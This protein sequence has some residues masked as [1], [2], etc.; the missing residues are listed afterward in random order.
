MKRDGIVKTPNQIKQTESSLPNGS[1]FIDYSE[2]AQGGDDGS[3]PYSEQGFI[4]Q[5]TQTMS[6]LS[7]G[8]NLFDQNVDIDL[9]VSQ[10]LSESE[11]H[12]MADII[13]EFK[14]H[15]NISGAVHIETE[16]TDEPMNVYYNLQISNNN[17]PTNNDSNLQIQ[18]PLSNQKT[19]DD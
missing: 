7:F 12:S 17:N 3:A 19:D 18:D 1:I 16:N 15:Y 8:D 2:G 9:T 11:I 13:D 6:G 4:E 10:D 14:Y 5:L